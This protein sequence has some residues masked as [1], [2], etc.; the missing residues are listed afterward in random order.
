MPGRLHDLPLPDSLGP[1]I[2]DPTTTD[3]P[4]TITGGTEGPGGVVGLDGASS[5]PVTGWA[6]DDSIPRTPTI[7][8]EN[9]NAVKPFGAI[10][11]PAQGGT[12]SGS[13]FANFG[14]LMTPRGNLIINRV[15]AGEENQF[16][17]S[18]IVRETQE[19]NT[20]YGF[21]DNLGS[22]L[23][24]EDPYG[25]RHPYYSNVLYY[26]LG[27]KIDGTWTVKDSWSNT[28]GYY[29]S[30]TTAYAKGFHTIYW[31]PTDDKGNGDGIGSRYFTIQNSGQ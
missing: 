10:D 6:L 7:K 31:S 21:S 24:L 17:Q 9:A 1:W 4:T 29:F 8:V 15:E 20:P 16:R 2:I 14:W 25:N 30:D 26:I 23:V 5:V 13:S 12:A 11:A 27:S 22:P 19:Y 28:I 3:A 18:K